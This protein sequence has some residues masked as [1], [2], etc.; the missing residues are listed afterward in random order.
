VQDLVN[1]VRNSNAWGNTLIIIT[2]DEHGGRW[3]HVAPPVVD[4]WGPGARVP[5]I[6]VSPFVRKG[7]IDHNLYETVSILKLIERRFGLAPLAARDA[8]PAVSDLTTA[9]S[10]GP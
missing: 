2:Y 8:N 10:V 6:L 3:D 9:L 7:Y 1:A 4:A 5:A